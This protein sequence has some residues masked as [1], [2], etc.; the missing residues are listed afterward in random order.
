MTVI[1]FSM[2]VQNIGNYSLM[3]FEKCLWKFNFSLKCRWKIWFSLVQK[4]SVFSQW[5]QRWINGTKDFTSPWKEA[6][7]SLVNSS[8][9]ES[10]KSI[11]F[12]RLARME[13]RKPNWRTMI[14]NSQRNPRSCWFLY[15]VIQNGLPR[16]D[17]LRRKNIPSLINAVPAWNEE[18]SHH[19]M[20]TSPVIDV[21]GN[22][23]HWSSVE[24]VVLI[25]A[26]SASFSGGKA[27]D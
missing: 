22:W 1:I 21:F 16:L 5:R 26:W 3:F 23:L 17:F 15:M 7:S 25:V 27:A 14:S 9:L 20:I 19:I 24:D 11:D 18:S 13:E 6:H 2:F 8:Q 4:K 12:V 10:L